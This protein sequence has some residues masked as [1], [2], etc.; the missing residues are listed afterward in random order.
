[1]KGLIL[2]RLHGRL[3]SHPYATETSLRLNRSSVARRPGRVL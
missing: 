2:R 1:M 3:C